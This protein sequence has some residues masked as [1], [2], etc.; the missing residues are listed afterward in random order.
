VLHGAVDAF[1]GRKGDLTPHTHFEE[2]Y[3]GRSPAAIVSA[4]RQI[5]GA[6][7]RELTMRLGGLQA[8]RGAI[9]LVSEGFPR[10]SPPASRGMRLPDLDGVVRA[11]SRYHVPIYTV[12]PSLAIEDAGAPGERDRSAATLQWLAAQTGGRTIDAA[13]LV[14]G[15]ARLKHDFETYYLLSYRPTQV[16]GR[17]HA[18]EIK[19]KR[20]D[21][22]VHAAPGYWSVPPATWRS[23]VS[24]ASPLAISRRALRRSPLIDAW[25]GIVRNPDGQAE[26]VITWE[27]KVH[28][29]SAPQ[30]VAL[31]AQTTSGTSLFDGRLGQVGSATMPPDNARFQV[32]SGRIEIDMTIFDAGGKNIDVDTRDFDVPDWRAQKIG[33]VLLAPEVV[34]A[35]TLRDFQSAIS[36]PDAAPS[37]ARTFARADRLLIRV[38][39]FDPSGTAVTVTAKVLNGW[40]QPMREIDPLTTTPRDGMPQF[41]LPLAW[42]VPGEY[43]LELQA[44]NDH[45]A[46]KQRITF[47]VTG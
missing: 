7:L 40:G 26:M 17:F 33:P 23:V 32:A 38:P 30:V 45:G 42:L 25:V 37:S 39:A 34:R 24:S 31:K 12:N 21:A 5:V 2:L 8:D 15:M 28:G 46:V 20:R 41:A 3:I 44:V 14:A 4:R 27:P 36:N 11:A 9:V 29:L 6:D 10:E 43:L 22:V 13:T 19:T 16:D 35:R 47:R 1:T 18:I